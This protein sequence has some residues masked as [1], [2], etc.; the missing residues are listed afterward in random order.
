MIDEVPAFTSCAP[1]EISAINV[2]VNVEIPAAPKNRG[3]IK[4]AP[5]GM[6][7]AEQH[8]THR[9]TAANRRSS[10]NPTDNGALLLFALLFLFL[11]NEY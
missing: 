3:I 9:Y 5:P 7:A 1:G 10:S 2:M 11:Y 8:A 6:A 4:S